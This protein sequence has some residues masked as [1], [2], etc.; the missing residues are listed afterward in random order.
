M[1]RVIRYQTNKLAECVWV[2]KNDSES[3]RNTG[4]QMDRSNELWSTEAEKTNKKKRHETYHWV[5][6]LQ[7]MIK[8][9]KKIRLADLTAALHGI[10]NVFEESSWQSGSP[11]Y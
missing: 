9:T 8:V 7:Q 4:A 11:W 3:R 1:Y 2:H 6:I 10:F 5:L